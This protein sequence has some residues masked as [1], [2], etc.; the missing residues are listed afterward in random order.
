VD[1]APAFRSKLLHEITAALGIALIHSKPYQPQ[2][3]GKVE[4]FFRTVQGQFLPTFQ[5]SSL[6]ELN[7]VFEH[8]I[9]TV[10]QQ[11]PHGATG[12][13]PLKRFADHMECIRPAP[14]HLEDYFRKRARRRV[15]ADRTVALNSRLY[16]APVALIGKPVTLLYHEHDPAR[17]EIHFE[18]QS[19][20]RLTPVDLH[21]NCRVQRRCWRD[22]LIESKDQGPIPSGRLS[23]DHREDEP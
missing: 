5:G 13:P 18:G 6:A 3:R 2:G 8:W 21:V 22:R 4:R 9:A 17:I 14:R 7:Q 10:Y 15:A 20:G 11:R 16:E 23:F 1:N 19:H 12:E